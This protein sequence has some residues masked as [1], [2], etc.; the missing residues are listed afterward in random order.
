MVHSSLSARVRVSLLHCP[1][2][3]VRI[4]VCPFP[5]FTSIVVS[6]FCWLFFNFFII[7]STLVYFT[8]A[9]S[10]SKLVNAKTLLDQVKFHSGRC[11]FKSS[12]LVRG[13]VRPLAFLTFF[14]S[15]HRLTQT[16]L[17]PPL[18]TL[19]LHPPFFTTLF[20]VSSRLI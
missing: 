13:R 19:S 11:S 3:P 9:T 16:P 4:Q 8:T 7:T 15:L 18:L 20:P 10:L 2:A 17:P 14:S 6:S 12:F 5:W 1:P